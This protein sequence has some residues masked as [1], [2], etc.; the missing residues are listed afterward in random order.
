MKSNLLYKG[1]SLPDKPL[2]SFV[3]PTYK[4][5]SYLYTAIGGILAQN[6]KGGFTEYEIIVI[7]NDPNADLSE[8]I[9]KY[10]NCNISFYCNEEN[11]GQVGNLNQGIFLA[12]GKYVSIIHDD[13][14]I[15]PNYFSSVLPFLTSQQ[16]DYDC[17]IPSCYLQYGKYKFD[18]RHKFLSFCYLYRFLYRKK[19][20]CVASDAW[21]YTFDDIYGPPSCGVIFL[22]KAL[23]DFGMFKNERGAAWDF[24]NFREFHKIKK[25][26]FLHSY[27]GVRR[28]E[29]GM[30]AESRVQ[31]EF[32]ADK[33]MILDVDEADHIFIRKFRTVIMTRK[34]LLH[35][36]RFRFM[37]KSYLY[38][39]NLD[40]RKCVS[41]FKYSKVE[42]YE[43]ELS[44]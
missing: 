12:R 29:T 27:V 23:E 11:Y 37:Q 3:I 13:D 15:L 19:L 16:T 21:I 28:C 20:T 32:K 30:S 7:C 26:F 34:P 14:M 38:S 25:V 24:Y 22:K 43:E 42:R 36:L 1:E 10:K 2:L 44:Q 39:Y 9:R 35:F 4:N 41:F 33:Q 18:F 8:F 6:I 40:L 17:I 5:F 31:Q